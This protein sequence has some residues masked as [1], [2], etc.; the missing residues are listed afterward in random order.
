M[1]PNKLQ[2]NNSLYIKFPLKKIFS[3]VI[4]IL[5]SEESHLETVFGKTLSLENIARQNGY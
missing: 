4:S 3:P 5:D 2:F 1:T